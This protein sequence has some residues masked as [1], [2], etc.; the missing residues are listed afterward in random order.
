MLK[1][2]YKDIAVLRTQLLDEQNNLCMLCKTE[3]NATDAVLDHNHS[4]GAIRGVLH[5]GC[6]L[7]LGKIENNIKRNKITSDM[8]S[9]ILSNYNDYVIE[10]KGHIH[11][12]YKLP[13][14]KKRKRKLK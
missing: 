14:T 11:P 9:N 6:N 1:M 5:R 8:L 13:G 3:V 4:N 12:T 7:F 2:K 10:D